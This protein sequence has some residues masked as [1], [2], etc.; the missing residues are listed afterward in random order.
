MTIPPRPAPPADQDRRF[1]PPIA[2]A[3]GSAARPP[4]TGPVAAR[5]ASTLTHWKQQ[6]L[7]LSK[8]NRA[9]NFRVQK[10]STV[11]IVDEQPAEVFRHLALRGEAMRFHPTLASPPAREK[12]A[13]AEAAAST[14]TVAAI[15]DEEEDHSLEADFAPYDPDALDARHR[16]D[17]LQCA[18][19]PE[20]L[21]KSLRR[22]D[23][24]ARSTLEEQGVNALYLALGMLH[25]KE[26]AESDVVLRAPILL[27]PVELTR[28]SARSGYVVR[29]T[30]DDPMVNPSLAEYLRRS[31]GI[32][33]P[34]LPDLSESTDY[35]VQELFAR[36]TAAIANQ[37]DWRVTTDIYLALFSFQKLVM[38]KDLE[39]NAEVFADHR[40]V[41]QLITREGSTAIG[42]P[43]PVR[44][45]PL[46]REFP[47]EE[48]FQVVDADSSQLR[49][50]AAVARQHDLVL[51][52]PPGTGKSQTIT[53]LIA[54]ALG[55]GKSVLFVAEKMAA[56]DVVHSRL[57]AAGLGEFCLEMHS[58]KANKRAVM[59][60]IRTAL[61]ASLQRPQGSATS[62]ERLR[63]V[64][65]TLDEYVAAVHTPHGT[66]ALSPYRG[67][68]ELGLVLDA[69]KLPLDGAID[70]VT[71]ETLAE[72]GRRLGDLAAQATPVGDPRVH[73]WRDAGAT[74]YGESTLDRIEMLVGD[75][76][77]QH[78]A[79]VERA[80]EVERLLGLSVTDAT[81][82]ETARRAAEVVGRSP[83]AS[84]EVLV[85]PMWDDTGAE[86]AALIALVRGV[87]E[88]A[89]RTGGWFTDDAL[90]QEHASDA[91]HVERKAQG[92]FSFLAFLDGRWRSIKRRW[93]SYRKA[94]YD[95]PLLDQAAD[96][97]LVDRLQ[98]D[99]KRL[100]EA[101]PRARALFGAHWRGEASDI[102]ALDAY[103]AWVAELRGLVALHRLPRQLLEVAT[104]AKP[105]VS[106][107][108]RL[109]DAV[110][111]FAR[112]VAELTSLVRWP[113]SYH[114]ARSYAAM[115]ARVA[116]LDGQRALAARWAAFEGARATAAETPAASMVAKAMQGEVPFGELP[117]AFRR[118][119]FQQ[120]L[121]AAVKDRPALR[122]FQ[123]LSH[124][125]RVAE[126]RELDQRVL[127]E[128][129]VQL[130][131]RLRESVQRKLQ[132]PDAAAGMP[133]LR[134]EMARQRNL[135]PLR[136]T[137][138]QAE[139]AIRAIKPCFL[140]SPLSVAQYLDGATTSFDLVLFDEASQ[141]PS[142][143]AV[144]AIARGRQL[145]VVGDPKQLPPTNFF[146]ISAGGVAAPVGEDGLPMYEDAESVL[147]E[148]MGAGVPVTRLKWHYR[149][150]HESLIT[151]SNVSFYDADLY[152]FP[153][154]ETGGSEYGLSFEYVQD[155]V[156]EGKGLN[157]AEARR[158][159]DAVVEHV[160]TRPDESLGVGTFNMRQQLAIQDELELRRRQDPSIEFFFAKD[161]PEPFFVKNLENIQGDERDVI[162]LSVTYA[163][164]AEGR[165]RYNFGPIN[166]E[167]GWRRLNVLTT[168][169]RKRMRVFSSMRGDDIS[170]AAGA[171][172]GPRLLREFLKYAEHGRLES[173][174]AS[175]QSATESPFERDVLTELVRRG[176]Q[177]DPQVGVA[178]YRIDLG[179][180]DP[181][182]PGRW[183]CGIECDGV[184]YHASET[185]RDRDR[186]RQ[187]VLE[188]RGWTIVRVWSTDWFKDRAGQIDRLVAAI[189][190]A[191]RNAAEEREQAAEAR[192]RAAAEQAA[193]E[194]ER[195]AQALAAPGGTLPSDSYVRP[196][197]PEY[198]LAPGQGRFA[199]SDI[200]ETPIARVVSAVVSVV[201]VESPVH[202]D[203]VMSRVAG[204]WSTRLGSRV[205]TKIAQAVKTAV[206]DR[207]VELRGEFLQRPGAPVTVRSRAGMRIP[208]DRIAPEEYQGAIRLVL[209]AAGS[210]SRQELVNEVR[211]LLG[212][213]RSSAALVEACERALEVMLGAGAIGE[214]SGGVA[215]RG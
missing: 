19:T 94:G 112:T 102:S 182:M 171:S 62:G 77:V 207:A 158:V 73:P 35:D 89:A 198:Q 168:R 130:V 31:F 106:A 126:F 30:D 60:E 190:Q 184:A 113:S 22:L 212:Y 42:L 50:I 96:L 214:G 151:F 157:M 196:V 154:V 156:Y 107:V 134:K 187:Q 185:A 46:D 91:A 136:R 142:E 44:T 183:I 125:Q 144:G 138:Q 57:V 103:A 45:M 161:R 170:P 81:S 67:F 129:R 206:N 86:P 104:T 148:Y 13:A 11:T 9:L 188:G 6:L 17:V 181:E 173:A 70:D 43:E 108:T 166:G 128:N 135:S 23:E 149:S 97:R 150:A 204:M 160:K 98:A 169:A 63:R 202:V 211:A 87:Q 172:Q 124:E 192:T 12:Q 58:T 141:L 116:E 1:E 54:Q 179:V 72:I 119:F 66:L 5:V 64:R 131:T 95:K 189:E 34:E 137:I 152:T 80:A 210:L 71:P 159:V 85:G 82:F 132:E 26:S 18:A 20:A 105:D 38:Y 120:W 123:T 7:D 21:D 47:P 37:R 49:A 27:L 139:A 84:L 176:Y 76:R 167:N 201:D 100:D 121:D 15:E 93:L 36:T 163:K 200:L 193:A 88:L 165:L 143:E 191:K 199:S 16:D 2:G 186:L 4:L 92:A 25:H 213:G 146:A 75:A 164:D 59:Q 155:G 55:A 48:T 52:G 177:V 32:T 115:A 14:A 194:A 79:L 39:Q 205:Q 61:D 215:L 28:R 8:R 3:P 41:Q 147:E 203:D 65:T 69:P 195:L 24:Q 40:L 127:H 145:V 53:N 74:Y 111:R 114:D 178:G 162:F 29:A 110:E 209:G 33:L 180:R 174:I 90:Q 56:L 122:Q 101:A 68:G 99:R 10:V 153:S 197:V 208:A 133:F 118:A 78:A 83:G 140:M 117:R 175:A 51:E 109:A